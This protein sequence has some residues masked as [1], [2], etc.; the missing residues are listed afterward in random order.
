MKHKLGKYDDGYRPVIFCR[1]CGE[2]VENEA[3]DCPGQPLPKLLQTE[4]VTFHYLSSSVPIKSMDG[5]SGH[6][7]ENDK[8]I[9][10]KCQELNQNKGIE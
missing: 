4:T 9:L 7:D 6:Y 10:D 1:V 3:A 2:E 8:F 5:F